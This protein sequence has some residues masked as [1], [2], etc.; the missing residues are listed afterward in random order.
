MSVAAL[1]IDTYSLSLLPTSN[2]AADLGAIGETTICYKNMSVNASGTSVATARVTGLAC[3]Y[4]IYSEQG[5]YTKAT[6][7][8][9]FNF[10]IL[11]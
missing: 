10:G 9:G 5:L 2:Y 8:Y 6:P 7:Q 11:V 4:N 1:T 3:K